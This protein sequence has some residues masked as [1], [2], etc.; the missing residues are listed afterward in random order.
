MLSC[1]LEWIRDSRAFPSFHRIR[2]DAPCVLEE[3]NHLLDDETFLSRFEDRSLPFEEWNH[4]AHVKVAYLYLTR[5][6]FGEAL[7]RV[8]SG[9]QA[10][11]EAHDVLDGPLEGYH[12]TLTQA[13][14]TLV[15]VTIR[16]YG[17]GTSADAFFDDHPQLGQPKN[18]RLFYSRERITSPRAKW[19][20]VEPDLTALP[21][22]E[23][24]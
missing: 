10:Y 3:R 24:S 18:L 14:L 1:S 20:F 9:I 19:E 21:R 7:A 5:L 4:R 23:E 8:R 12:E 6:A 17:A 11:N 22:L 15:A 16:V 2:D 13:W